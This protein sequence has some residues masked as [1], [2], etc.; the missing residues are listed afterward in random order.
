MALLSVEIPDRLLTKLRRTGRS[1]QDVI[2]E[3]LEKT[4]NA[5]PVQQPEMSREEVERRLLES[6]FVRNPDEYDC[7][8]AQEWRELTEE[9]KQEHLKEMGEFFF[10]DSPASNFIIES[11]RVE[12]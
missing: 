8:A 4:L 9:E 5:K 2:I 7:L 1:A 11:R 10:P 12:L 6:G 3:A